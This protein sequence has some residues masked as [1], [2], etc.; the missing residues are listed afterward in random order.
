[1]S[2]VA[3]AIRGD[4]APSSR[5]ELRISDIEVLQIDDGGV[6]M[7]VVVHTD[8]GVFGVGEVGLRSRQLASRGAIEHFKPL[9]LGQDPFRTEHLWQ[10][11]ARSGFYPADRALMSAIS[12][13]DIAL[14]DIKGKALGLP[15]YELLGGA[16]RDRVQCYR[17][18]VGNNDAQLIESAHAALEEGWTVVRFG[19]PSEGNIIDSRRATRSSIQS[20]EA[21]RSEFGDRI[22]MILDVHTRLDLGDATNLCRELEPVDMYFVEDPLRWENTTIY[23]TLRQR[24]TVPLAAGEHAA[25][26]W[27]IRHLIEND[28]VDFARFDLC[29]VGGLTEAKKIAGW[30]ETHHI[31]T[32]THNPLGPIAT[33]ASFQ[34]NLTLP[35]FGIQEQYQIPGTRVNDVFPVQMHMDGEWMLP[36]SAPGL[37]LEVDLDA[38]RAHRAEI[39]PMPELRRPDGS[40]A[41]W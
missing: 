5:P 1:M 8:G 24:T 4:V 30:C 3:P 2:T 9:L 35:A 36:T 12:A 15:I 38:A 40:V 29:I 28:A 23:D 14:W 21:L 25:S 37:G 19:V 41:N 33:A 16:A 17:H 34:L 39:V 20:C 27:D 13:I 31:R 10:V 18:I 6:M 7:M 22:D 11:M 26:K 32:A